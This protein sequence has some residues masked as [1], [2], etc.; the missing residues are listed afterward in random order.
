[1][2]TLHYVACHV[3]TLLEYIQFSEQTESAVEQIR[4]REK[5]VFCQ[6]IEGEVSAKEVDQSLVFEIGLLYE[7]HQPGRVRIG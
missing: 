1:M 7:G 2:S 6:S 3:H 5:I 4:F